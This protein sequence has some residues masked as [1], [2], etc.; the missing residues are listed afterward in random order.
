MRPDSK[1]SA[2]LGGLLLC[3]SPANGSELVPL[4][5]LPGNHEQVSFGNAVD[6]SGNVIV[7]AAIADNCGGP[8]VAV[9]WHDGVG[10]SPLPG[11]VGAFTANSIAMDGHSIVGRATSSEAPQGESFLWTASEGFQL[12]QDNSDGFEWGTADDVSGDGTTVVGTRSI[13]PDLPQAYLWTGEL[14]FVSVGDLP[15]GVQSSTALAIS[16]DGDVVVGQSNSFHGPE[17]FRWTQADGIVGLGDL[18]GGDFLS[19]AFDTSSNG[20]VIVG[21]GASAASV[22]E[23]F[24]WDSSSGIKALGFLPG[25]YER[26]L[27]LGVSGDGS[28]II[29]VSGLTVEEL[30]A[31]TWD[32]FRGM[33][34]MQSVLSDEFGLNVVL[35]GWRLAWASDISSDGKNIVGWG[36]N[37][38]GNTEAWLV[39]LDRPLSAPEPATLLLLCFGSL[40]VLGTCKGRWDLGTQCTS[41]RGIIGV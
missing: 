5:F 30:T 1:W 18:P 16:Q 32:N 23:A 22:E 24:R 12:L 38:D 15:G 19:V 7:G 14:G 35:A 29:G 31:F 33:R 39:R 37:P 34:S 41:R 25:L 3:F 40:T 2:V 21:S 26:S 13:A 4:G 17:A 11:A 8:Q 20:I 9:S 27:A 6:A 36:Y 10:L 28:A